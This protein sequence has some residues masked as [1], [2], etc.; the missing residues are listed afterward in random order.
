[1]EIRFTLNALVVGLVSRLYCQ[2]WSCW[3][4]V[5]LSVSRGNLICLPVLELAFRGKGYGPFA[6]KIVGSHHKVLGNDRAQFLEISLFTTEIW[7]E[8]AV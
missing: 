7:G 1:M 4:L 5:L 3:I 8:W 6:V 2:F